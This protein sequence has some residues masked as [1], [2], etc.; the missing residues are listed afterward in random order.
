MLLSQLV[1]YMDHLESDFDNRISKSRKN[2]GGG[3][4]SAKNLSPKVAGIG[5]CRQLKG[6]VDSIL[7]ASI[8]LL[9]DLPNFESFEGLAKGLQD[10]VKSQERELYDAWLE[11]VEN[12]LAND[13][14]SSQ[15]T[16][17]ATDGDLQGQHTDRQLQ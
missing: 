11:E 7:S 5:Y 4:S 16:K 10:M 8:A 14:V 6:R 3:T 1:E 17:G 12:M 2:G 15:M 13:E 9:K